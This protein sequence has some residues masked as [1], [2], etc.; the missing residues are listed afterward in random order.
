M[1]RRRFLRRLALGFLA[2]PLAAQ[3]QPP[4]GAAR[5]AVLSSAT[6]TSGLLS[7]LHA[8][9]REYGWTEGQNLRVE[10]RSADGRD[11]RL[12]ALAAEIARLDIDVVVALHTAA[13]VAAKHGM[14]GIPIVAVSVV[15]PVTTGL[16]A[17]LGRPGS[18]LTGTTF[19]MPEVA[20]KIVEFIAEAAPGLSSL[21]VLGDSTFPGWRGYWDEAERASRARGIAL[22]LV[23][24][25][26]PAE[27]PTA[28]RALGADRPGALYVVGTSAIA[29]D[30]DRVVH[31][32]A[33]NRLPAIYS[34]QTFVIR[35]GLMS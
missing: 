29:Q 2:T 27:L 7:A 35:G 14:R 13:A 4:T 33:R 15:D 9:L 22:R 31:F 11:E 24:I 17:S 20:G 19:H 16:I 30:R 8:G 3:A 12:G 32:A 26:R 5:I 6:P 10:Y 1:N 25:G 21:A 34:S 23:H 18:N 28:L